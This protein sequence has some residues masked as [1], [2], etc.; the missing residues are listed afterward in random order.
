MLSERTSVILKSGSGGKQLYL[1][2]DN[3]N[4][5]FW[6]VLIVK[7]V[8]GMYSKNLIDRDSN[9]V[10]PRFSPLPSMKPL[11]LAPCQ[12]SFF[13]NKPPLVE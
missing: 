13:Y 9:T 4:Q 6:A 1:K 12:S 3:F 11:E 7:E 8:A 5:V 2:D 10:S